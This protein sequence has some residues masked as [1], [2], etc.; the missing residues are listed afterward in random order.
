MISFVLYSSCTENIIIKSPLEIELDAIPSGTPIDSL[1][2]IKFKHFYIDFEN[3]SKY[4]SDCESYTVIPKL[5]TL[6]D[7]Y[8]LDFCHDSLNWYDKGMKRL[9]DVIQFNKVT[10]PI[11]IDST[12]QIHIVHKEKEI[13]QKPVL[14]MDTVITFD[15]KFLIESIHEQN[16][17]KFQADTLFF[18]FS[19][20]DTTFI[21]TK[22]NIFL[23][24]KGGKLLSL[25]HISEPTRPY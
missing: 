22:E 7:G 19:V 23:K 13:Y 10:I 14:F 15:P 11:S 1:K 20:P 5:D 3:P 6:E 21:N 18:S 25:I 4:E 2:S 24:Y 16:E 9:N 12:D 8:Y 17:I